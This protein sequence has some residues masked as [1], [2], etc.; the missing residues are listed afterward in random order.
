MPQVCNLQKICH[1]ERSLPDRLRTG[2]ES[3]DLMFAGAG[4]VV[5]RNFP[6]NRI[7]FRDYLLSAEC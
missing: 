5:A 3:K 1:P 4:T 6:G 2:N 7:P